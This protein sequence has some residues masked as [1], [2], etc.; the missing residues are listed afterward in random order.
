MDKYS[1]YVKNVE[2]QCGEGVCNVR[3]MVIDKVAIMKFLISIIML[4]P[5]IPAQMR[6]YI[7]YVQAK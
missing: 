3:I 2:K 4:P 5:I 7:P 1:K 6:V